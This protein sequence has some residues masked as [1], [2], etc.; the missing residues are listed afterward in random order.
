MSVSAI[1]PS[2]LVHANSIGKKPTKASILKAVQNDTKNM[3][4]PANRISSLVSAIE[5]N[6]SQFL[7]GTNY[8]KALQFVGKGYGKR[9]KGDKDYVKEIKTIL[10]G[11][12]L[13]SSALNAIKKA[14]NAVHDIPIIASKPLRK[15]VQTVGKVGGPVKTVAKAVDK[16]I[17][18]SAQVASLAPKE[19]P[20]WE[21]KWRTPQPQENHALLHDGIA[22]AWRLYRAKFLGPG[23]ALASNIREDIKHYGSLDEMLKD[24]HWL[25]LLDKY[26]GLVHDIKYALAP[27]SADPAKAVI[28]ADRNFIL[29]GSKLLLNPKENRLNILG[30]LVPITAKFSGD[31]FISNPLSFL[32]KNPDGSLKKPNEEDVK[33]YNE[34]LS[35]IPQYG[36]SPK[37]LSNNI[38]KALVDEAKEVVNKINA[39]K[40]GD[41]KPKANA[42]NVHLQTIKE[43]YPN[44]RL[45]E[46]LMK[47]KET[48]K[49]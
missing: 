46:Q 34:V 13:F 23:T 36:G 22:P 49:K 16:V 28:D 18:K 1:L 26:G 14:N 33:L 40:N 39:V 3:N 44:M 7:R 15:V 4:I 20:D 2:L 41:K 35:K 32:D 29:V 10:N 6:P 24:K 8:T 5:S 47:A 21:Y 43:K 37:G 9:G 19:N 42:W 27:L 45:K 25:T 17:E 12:G 38:K 31:K 48:Y 11:D 30:S